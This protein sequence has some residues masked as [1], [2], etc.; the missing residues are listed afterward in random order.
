VRYSVALALVALGV[1]APLSYALQAQ[2]SD[3]VITMQPSGKSGAQATVRVSETAMYVDGPTSGIGV[4][5]QEKA[6]DPVLFS[7]R[8]WRE[9]E[10][11]RVVVYAKLRDKR[12]PGGSTE[13]P[14]ATFSL[15][16][17]ESVQV[18]QAEKWGGV[19]LSVGATAR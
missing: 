9:A 11:A 13:T 19:T 18:P 15:A 17:G 2:R 5:G 7:L 10:K 3:L 4:P 6:P 1:A 8:A 12:A 14:I 16:A